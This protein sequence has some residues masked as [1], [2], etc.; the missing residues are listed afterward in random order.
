MLLLLLSLVPS[1]PIW[2]AFYLHKEFERKG[3]SRILPT[4]SFGSRGVCKFGMEVLLHKEFERR[5]GGGILPTQ[6]FG[7]RGSLVRGA[8][9]MKMAAFFR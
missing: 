8:M 2:M 1:F 7:S 6:S 4:Q 3:G 5:G 9:F